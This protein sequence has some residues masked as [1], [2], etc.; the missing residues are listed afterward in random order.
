MCPGSSSPRFMIQDWSRIFPT[1]G[2]KQALNS[3]PVVG[4]MKVY[5]DFYYYQGGIYRFSGGDFVGNHA[6]LLI[7]YDDNEGCWICK[8]SWGEAWGS[9]S[10]IKG[11]FRIAYDDPT[12]RGVTENGE[13]YG[14]EAYSVTVAPPA[15]DI[16][17]YLPELRQTLEAVQGNAALRAYLQYWVC[18]YGTQP[19]YQAALHDIA[20]NVRAIMQQAPPSYLTWFCQNL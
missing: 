11:H 6:I 9:K 17:H 18:G 19:A 16:Q 4:A 12:I 1:D 5:R 3:G 2:I 8:N 10:P 14:F 13:P 7:G 15:D 20:G